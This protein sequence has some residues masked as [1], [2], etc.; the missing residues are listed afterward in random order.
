MKVAKDA[1][2]TVNFIPA[3]ELVAIAY[4]ATETPDHPNSALA[5]GAAGSDR[6]FVIRFYMDC[7][8]YMVA[9]N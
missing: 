7:F 2:L 8:E 4:S 5:G 6:G 9:P 3:Q 1:I